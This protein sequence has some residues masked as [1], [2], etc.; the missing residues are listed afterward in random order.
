[1]SK[2][3]QPIVISYLLLQDERKVQDQGTTECVHDKSKTY[4][5]KN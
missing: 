2:I 3:T 4:F 5:D 1:M